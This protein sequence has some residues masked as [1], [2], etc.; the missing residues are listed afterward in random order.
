MTAAAT[1]EH[2][3]R[4]ILDREPNIAHKVVGGAI[5]CTGELIA[6]IGANRVTPVPE[7]FPADGS[8]F[9][10]NEQGCSDSA[11]ASEPGVHDGPV[12]NPCPQYGAQV[13]IGKPCTNCGHRDGPD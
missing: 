5:A 13:A 6:S 4:V 7:P 2:P 12:D 8:L 1:L 10:C 9:L 3:T 11:E